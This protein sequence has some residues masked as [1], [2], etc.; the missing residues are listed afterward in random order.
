M[1]LQ[2]PVMEGDSAVDGGNSYIYSATI[3]TTA[4]KILPSSMTT[5]TPL[6]DNLVLA[7]CCKY[8]VVGDY[9]YSF[10]FT[11]AATKTAQHAKPVSQDQSMLASV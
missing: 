3:F 1:S 9:D 11:E 6:P 7:F 4:V 5:Y 10:I 2:P 8:K